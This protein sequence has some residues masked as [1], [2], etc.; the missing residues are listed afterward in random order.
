MEVTLVD[1]VPMDAALV[2]WTQLRQS[3]VP[4]MNIPVSLTFSQDCSYRTI[5]DISI[6]IIWHGK[7]IVSLM[8][9]LITLLT[10]SQ[11]LPQEIAQTQIPLQ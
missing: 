7:G 9:A 2:E 5:D 4:K 6:Q 8:M 10:G 3:E 11:H 1:V